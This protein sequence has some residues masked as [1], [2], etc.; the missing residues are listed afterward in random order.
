M[1]KAFTLVELLIVATILA[2]LAGLTVVGLAA[3]VQ[4]ARTSRTRAII[5][6]IDTLIM[7]RWEGYRTKSVAI[8]L[9]AGE[10]PM[11]EPFADGDGNG[12]W[13]IGESF[14]DTNGNGLYDHG[15]AWLRLLALRELQR[16]ELPDRIS[17]LC[18]MAELTDLTDGN[19]NAINNTSNCLLV[20][21][22]PLPS[23][24]A[25]G[26]SYKRLADRAIR[27]SGKPWTT[28]YQGAECLYLILSVLKDHD[29]S[30]LDYF[31]TD[32]IG[33]VD[34]DGMKEILDGWG[35]PL[36]FLRWTPG[37]V[38][39]NLA[40]TDQIADNTRPDPFDPLHVDGKETYE[41]RPL[42]YSAG[43]DG[44]YEVN[45]GNIV[46]AMPFFPNPTPAGEYP[47]DPYWFDGSS[48]LIGEPFDTDGDLIEGWKDNISN[49]YRP[50]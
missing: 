17:D 12:R 43:P 2:I 31:S 18:N 45:R 50:Q 38:A 25:A 9:R 16:V 41:I 6:K 46:Y 3:A 40:D 44:A 22:G 39:G 30:A 10:R 21:S 28:E 1:R 47:N 27:T 35:R 34:G 14:T 13:D 4:D 19:L 33:D 24:P 15:A 37:Y 49:H 42:I 29:K 7:E 20:S 26:R 5:D 48:P 32:E 11:P 23:M 36:E 8:R